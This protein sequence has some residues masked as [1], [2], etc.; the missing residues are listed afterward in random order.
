MKKTLSVSVAAYNVAATLREA[1][2]P[3]L[4]SGV[5]DALDIMIVDDGSKDNTS[6]IAAD[7]Q[8]KYPDSIRLIKKE[9][10]GWG[11]T[12]NCGI[13]N[14]IGKYFKQLDGD[15]YYSPENLKSYINILNNSNSDIVI[16]PY[17]TF[18][19]ETGANIT[20]ENCN[21]SC[22]IN[23]MLNLTEINSF[24][25]F[26]HSFA[27]KTELLQTGNVSVTEHCFYTD[28]EFVLKSCNQ[29]HTVMFLD[30]PIYY[31]RRAALGQSMSL[32]GFEKH[33]MEQYKVIENSLDY[34]K[35]NVDRAEIKG[36]YDK[37]L[38]GTCF[39]QYLIMLYISPTRKH[40]KDLIAYD[41]ML[42]QKAPQYYK[43]I[44]F[45]ELEILRKFHF[46][47][48]TFLAKK[49]KKRDNRFTE[50]GRLAN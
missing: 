45:E 7:Y 13:K 38:L 16:T 43:D 2:D 31:Y 37:L 29:A 15:D 36:I 24:N 8:K 33:Y 14:A 42:K 49:K 10:G 26:M 47:G 18:D 5:I 39:W 27:I 3:F 9:N 46:I 17:V 32:D 48:Y 11:S 21:P 28:T 41:K 50:D 19:S 4:E 34:M 6:E 1:I 44:R 20:T 30:I 40:K 25:P 35:E 12:V 22:P 23:V